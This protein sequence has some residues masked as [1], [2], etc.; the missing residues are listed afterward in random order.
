M[1]R[2]PFTKLANLAS[3]RFVRPNTVPSTAK[4]RHAAGMAN[5]FWISMTALCVEIRCRS[6]V[7]MRARSSVIVISR[8]PF[9]GPLRGN[10][11]SGSSPSTS[12]WKRATL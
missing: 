1:T 6:R 5:F 11:V 4:T 8:S 7:A 3:R 10:T 9:A 12:S 2:I